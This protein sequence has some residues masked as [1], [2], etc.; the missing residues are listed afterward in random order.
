MAASRSI[1]NPA[2]INLQPDISSFVMIQYVD[3]DCVLG[4][5]CTLMPATMAQSRFANVYRGGQRVGL[6][7]LISPNRQFRKQKLGSNECGRG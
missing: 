3:R 5:S 7:I 2:K 1:A 4:P 6:G